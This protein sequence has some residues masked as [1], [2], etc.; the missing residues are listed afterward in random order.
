MKHYDKYIQAANEIKETGESKWEYKNPF[1]DSPGT[2][3]EVIF[4]SGGHQPSFYAH[5]EYRKPLKKRYL[6]RTQLP[7]P[8]REALGKGTDYFCPSLSAFAKY[9]CC[10]WDDDITDHER[11]KREIIY[12]KRED[13]IAHTDALLATETD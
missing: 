2:W 6:K 11:L 8:V 3:F 7:E 5:C 10:S 1:S 4:D 12:L 13:A 9:V